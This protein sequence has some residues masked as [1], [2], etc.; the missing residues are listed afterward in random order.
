MNAQDASWIPALRLRVRQRLV[1][2]ALRS[3]RGVEVH[4]RVWWP[5]RLLAFGPKHLAVNQQER[6][7][8]YRRVALALVWPNGH[9]RS[10]VAEDDSLHQ[11]SIDHQLVGCHP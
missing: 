8:Q 2:D 9:G 6:A 4:R 10:L 5:R 3:T 1:T 7:G 11:S